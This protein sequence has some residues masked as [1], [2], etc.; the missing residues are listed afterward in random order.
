MVEG[1]ENGTLLHRRYRSAAIHEWGVKLDT[2]EFFTKKEIYW[3]IAPVHSHRF[4]KVQFPAQL[5]LPILKRS[6]DSYKCELVAIRK[7]PYGLWTGSGLGEEY[8]DTRSVLREVPARL[9][10][11]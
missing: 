9:V 4:L 8:L 3:Q 11:R 5:L 2:P 6:I 7:L 1:A 10:V